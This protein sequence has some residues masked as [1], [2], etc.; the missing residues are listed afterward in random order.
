MNPQ[1]RALKTGTEV[2]VACPG[3]LLDHLDRGNADLSGVEKLVLDEAD[4][5]LDMGFLPAIKRVLSHLPRKRHS[6]LF[7]ATFAPELEELTRDTLIDPRRVDVDLRG[8]G[9][10]GRARALSVRAAPEDPSRAEA[11]RSDRGE[12]GA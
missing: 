10:D 12:L 11:A 3:R 6:M 8:A 5:M 1:E 2:I 4:R 9:Q 7:S